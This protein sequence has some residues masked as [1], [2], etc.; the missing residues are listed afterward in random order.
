MGCQQRKVTA[1]DRNHITPS[2]GVHMVSLFLVTIT[3]ICCCRALRHDSFVCAGI[4]G[5]SNVEDRRTGLVSAH[6]YALLRAVRV[7]LFQFLW[8]N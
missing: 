7:S 1:R 6:A 4:G 3:Q 5:S 8:F 2:T